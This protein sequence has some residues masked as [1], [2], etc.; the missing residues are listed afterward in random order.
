MA[1][2]D[3]I[4]VRNK[5]KRQIMV[6]GGQ[7][8]FGG[9]GG[10]NDALEINL[11]SMKEALRE[12]IWGAITMGIG[13]TFEL[14]KEM[15]KTVEKKEEKIVVQLNPLVK[16]VDLNPAKA[17]VARAIPAPV[18]P[19]IPTMPADFPKPKKFTDSLLSI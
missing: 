6:C 5:T 1:I 11:K 2:P 16:A 4:Y 14:L 7:L 3:V 8:T 9:A 13:H 18:S 19:T 12:R 10:K 15:P 17:P